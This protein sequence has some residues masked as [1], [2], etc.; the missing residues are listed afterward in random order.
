MKKTISFLSTKL[1]LLRLCYTGLQESNF[2]NSRITVGLDDLRGFFQP[3][4][5]NDFKS[6]LNIKQA[7][8]AE[9][10]H[11]WSANII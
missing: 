1:M 6:Q 4:W 8:V 5:Y 9:Q 10:V 2:I 11:R 3:N 7:L